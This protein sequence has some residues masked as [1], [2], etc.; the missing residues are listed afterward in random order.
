M[1]KDLIN[2]RYG[3]LIAE[4]PTQRFHAGKIRT[5]WVCKCVSGLSYCI[6]EKE[7]LREKLINGNTRSCG[8][9]QKTT[10]IKST[11]GHYNS[12][13]WECWSQIGKR[14]NNPNHK[15]YKYYGGRGVEVCDRWSGENGFL[16]FLEDMGEVPKG[17]SIDRRNND[18]NY[19]P[20]N[21]SWATITQQNRNRRNTLGEKNV[22]K[23]RQMLENGKTSASIARIFNVSTTTILH[24]KWGKTWKGVGD[25]LA[26]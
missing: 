20:S 2:K 3:Y 16:N 12:R 4:Y 6:G 19:E 23:I 17:M 8:C 10:Q 14:C 5:F 26:R 11:H 25:G 18:G 9:L 13:T 24:I 15:E 21:C 1:K 22:I 7:V